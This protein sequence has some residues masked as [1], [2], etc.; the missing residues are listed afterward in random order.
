M[1]SDDAILSFHLSVIEEIDPYSKENTLIMTSHG[2]GFVRDGKFNAYNTTIDNEKKHIIGNK[3]I[4]DYLFGEL[5]PRIDPVYPIWNKFFQKSHIEK[6]NLLFREDISLGE[7][8]IFVLQSLL[9]T[10]DL[11]YVNQ[12][13]HV[14][15]PW[16]NITH[17]GGVLRS[18]EHFWYNQ[19]ANYEALKT[20]AD[21]SN[22]SILNKYAI[23]YIIDRP[24]T[25]ILFRYT[26]CQNIRLYSKEDIIDFF[27]QN[28]RPFFISH[29]PYIRYV[30]DK[31]VYRI[32][33]LII[34]DKM[35][36]A[37]YTSCLLN[38]T[39]YP[40]Q[41]CYKFYYMCKSLIKNIICRK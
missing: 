26:E 9:Y 35:N 12:V 19:Y 30:H 39:K 6:H 17:L 18:P 38:V 22:S 34:K 37:Y 16:K 13:S 23:D 36:I 28:V 24:I 32:A 41:W 2:E 14:I 40:K 21:Y 3:E 33:N 11:F 7:D 8:Q 25:R 5:N 29:E 20:L 15:L 10:R 4:V 31:W 1:D 27:R